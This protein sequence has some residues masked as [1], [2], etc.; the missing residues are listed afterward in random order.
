MLVASPAGDA[1]L[2][3]ELTKPLPSKGSPMFTPEQ[4][5]T[6]AAEYSRLVKTAN[7]PNE[8]REYQK[9][10]RSFAVLADNEQWLMDNQNKTVNGMEQ[11]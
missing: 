2:H 11:G 4:F 10:E 9:L 5:R 7:R 1:T 3:F 8:V 6:K